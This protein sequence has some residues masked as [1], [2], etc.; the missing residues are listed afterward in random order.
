MIYRTE[1][2]PPA[3]TDLVY[4]APFVIDGTDDV[5]DRKVFVVDPRVIPVAFDWQIP[6]FCFYDGQGSSGVPSGFW[7]F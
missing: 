6:Y 3:Q 1:S 2:P 5:G 4:H 7:H